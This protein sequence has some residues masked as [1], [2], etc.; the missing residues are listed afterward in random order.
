MRLLWQMTIYQAMDPLLQYILMIEEISLCT[1]PVLLITNTYNH[2][3]K[4]P[5]SV[6]KTRS[7]VNNTLLRSGLC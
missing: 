5:G 1:T 6:L 3:T 7:T 2:M 4:D